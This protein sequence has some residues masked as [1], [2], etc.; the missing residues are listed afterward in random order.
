MQEKPLPQAKA[1]LER[2]AALNPESEDA[3]LAQA[4]IHEIDR[5]Q[6]GMVAP[7]FTTTTLEGKPLR[8]SSLRG[9]VVLLD[10]WA[11]LI[12]IISIN[13]PCLSMEPRGE[14]HEFPRSQ[15]S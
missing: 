6:I 1:L 14:K 3:R 4:Y 10:F 12:L 2:V 9:K 7:D 15:D 8:L 13:Y 11:A 5:L